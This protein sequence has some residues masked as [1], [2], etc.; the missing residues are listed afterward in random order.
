M[1]PDLTNHKSVTMMLQCYNDEIELHSEMC[2]QT[3]LKFSEICPNKWQ[4]ILL[5]HDGK[6]L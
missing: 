2:P 1:T 3:R 5:G 6:L 4:V